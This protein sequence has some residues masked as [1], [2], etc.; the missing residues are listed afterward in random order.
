M[1]KDKNDVKK[2]NYGNL[3]LAYF[4]DNFKQFSDDLRNLN[5]NVNDMIDKD[6]YN[7]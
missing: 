2:I 7:N 1:D 5:T 3:F 4:V 6:N